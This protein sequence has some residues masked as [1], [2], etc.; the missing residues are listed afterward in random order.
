[1][2]RVPNRIKDPG[3]VCNLSAI[4]SCPFK[5]PRAVNIKTTL[6][7]AMNLVEF[8]SEESSGNVV[9]TYGYNVNCRTN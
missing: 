6:A 4:K 9:S 7:R 2:N 5:I 8:G 3:E 1:M